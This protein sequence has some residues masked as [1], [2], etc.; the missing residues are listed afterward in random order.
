MSF[1]R[2]SEA[3]QNEPLKKTAF[4]FEQGLGLALAVMPIEGLLI[5][6]NLLVSPFKLTMP[7]YQGLYAVYRDEDEDSHNIHC[8]LDWLIQSPNL[9]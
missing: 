7:F 1:P 9:K 5:E 8:F 4:V 2:I 3:Y 6:R